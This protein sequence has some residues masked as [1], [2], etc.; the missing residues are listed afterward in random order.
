MRANILDTIDRI[1]ADACDAAAARDLLQQADLHFDAFTPEFVDLLAA[2]APVMRR[3]VILDA[4]RKLAKLISVPT[5]STLLSLAREGL[6]EYWG[7]EEAARIFAAHG[8]AEIFDDEPLLLRLISIAGPSVVPIGPSGKRP[9]T[10]PILRLY[11]VAPER[12]VAELTRQIMGKDERRRV[13]ASLAVRALVRGHS[14][15]APALAQPLVSTVIWAGYNTDEDTQDALNSTLGDVLRAEPEATDAIVEVAWAGSDVAGRMAMLAAYDDALR[16]RDLLEISV[17]LADVTVR[18]ALMALA[19]PFDTELPRRG[20]STLKHVCGYFSRSVQVPFDDL[21]AALTSLCAEA[22]PV[23]TDPDVALAWFAEESFRNVARDEVSDSIVSVARQRPRDFVVACQAAWETAVDGGQLIL[24]LAYM[25]S[26]LAI[27][28]DLVHEMEPLWGSILAGSDTQAKVVI[29]GNLA[30]QTWP[31]ETP[32]PAA[33][34]ALI[35]DSVDGTDPAMAERAA[36]AIRQIEVPEERRETLA[37]R[38][39]QWA[40]SVAEFR[41]FNRLARQAIKS[42]LHV[43]QDLPT[44]QAVL[45][46]ALLAVS[47]MYAV[48]AVEVLRRQRELLAHP[49]WLPT[50]ISLLS[51]HEDRHFWNGSGDEREHLVRE[52]SRLAPEVIRPYLG[53]LITITTAAAGHDPGWGWYVADI[54]SYWGFYEEAATIAR[55]ALAG[56]TERSHF[57]LSRQEAV[58]ALS[59]FEFE[60]AVA[61][62]DLSGAMTI[63]AAWGPA[64]AEAK[65]WE[66]RNA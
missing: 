43:V 42:S 12:L 66:E 36:E 19:A 13:R 62:G 24:H 33:L 20:A 61:R 11:S 23:S 30:R 16:H 14:E 34:K 2:D 29:L 6:I 40:Y 5:A 17:P 50:V 41:R 49:D 65:A 46:L 55:A 35:F 47:R 37:F 58:Q 26:K 51:E 3:G 27:H 9:L 56:T 48:D 32:M 54:V 39:A 28:R 8:T 60:A 18:R 1:D 38:L 15:A 64:I 53:N 63:A 52:M 57:P 10:G 25:V 45:K 21:F 7:L 22:P 31:V 59:N 44:R 4:L